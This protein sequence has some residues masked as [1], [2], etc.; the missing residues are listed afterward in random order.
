MRKNTIK[1]TEVCIESFLILAFQK[2]YPELDRIII[3]ELVVDSLC[4]LSI[5]LNN[6]VVL[7]MTGATTDIRF[8]MMSEI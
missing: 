4:E 6:T 2:L 3:R 7:G 1:H 8:K 5:A